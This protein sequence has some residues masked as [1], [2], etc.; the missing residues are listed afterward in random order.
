MSLPPTLLISIAAAAAVWLSGRRPRLALA[1][2]LALT[3]SMPLLDSTF[4]AMDLVIVLVAYRVTRGTQLPVAWL[5]ASAFVALTVTDGWQRVVFDRSFAVPS[6][7]YPALLTALAVGLGA[8]SRRV[9]AQRDLL[10]ALRDVDRR[11]AVSDERRRIAR[12]IHDIAAHH[13][14]AVVVRTRLAMKIDTPATY[15]EATAF[16]ASTAGEALDSIRHVV[17]VLNT[18]REVPLMPQATLADLEAYLVSMEAAGLQVSADITTGPELDLEVQVAAMRIVQEATANVLRHRGPGPCW[19]TV[20]PGGQ[21]VQV[22]VEDDGPLAPVVPAAGGPEG[23]YGLIGMQERAESC[24]GHLTVGPSE[25]G[26][27]RVAALLPVP[28]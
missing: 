6:V 20:A 13:L 25:R 28:Q 17:H 8:E 9:V 23:G 11:R 5:A 1:L 24:G 12:D 27:W 21:A 15:E 2:T 4:Q 3:I 26:G 7:L 19:L 18:E 16:A 10:V 22:V 14:S